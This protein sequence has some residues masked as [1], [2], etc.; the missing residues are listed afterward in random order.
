MSK[1]LRGVLVAM[2]GRLLAPGGLG[3]V[4]ALQNTL[5]RL[6]RMMRPVESRLLTGG[7]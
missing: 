5:V 3:V 4:K 1:K 2:E 6:R 7:L